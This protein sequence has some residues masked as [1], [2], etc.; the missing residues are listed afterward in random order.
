MIQDTNQDG[1]T[2]TINDVWF[3]TNGM[4]TARNTNITFKDTVAALPDYRGAGRVENLA[5]DM[6]EI[7]RKVA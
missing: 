2:Q 5:V 3:M 6:N 7:E 1:I 4:D